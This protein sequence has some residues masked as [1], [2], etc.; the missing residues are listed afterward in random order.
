MSDHASRPGTIYFI[1]EA[2]EVLQRMV[3]TRSKSLLSVYEQATEKICGVWYRVPRKYRKLL[4]AEQ[5]YVILVW[6]GSRQADLALAGTIVLLSTLSTEQFASVLEPSNE[7]NV[8]GAGGTAMI[9]INAGEKPSIHMT[10]ILTGLFYEEDKTKVPLNVRLESP[11]GQTIFSGSMIVDKVNHDHNVIEYQSMVSINVLRMLTRG[12]LNL[13]VESRHTRNILRIT[14]KIIPHAT[15]EV[16]QTVL[17]PLLASDSTPSINAMAWAYIN[18]HG[19]LVYNI[20]SDGLNDHATPLITLLDE[21]VKP[22]K[23]EPLKLPSS[24]IGN[25]ANG[26]LNR[27]KPRFIE[28]FYSN[29]LVIKIITNA[30]SIL[31]GKLIGRPVGGSRSSTEPMLL[32]SPITP[33]SSHLMLKSDNTT[34]LAHLAG[35]VW[36][37][38]DNECTVQYDITINDPNVQQD[39]ELYLEDRPID[40]PNAPLNV[41]LLKT[42]RADYVEGF[43]M[44]LSSGKLNVLERS[45]CI[46]QVKGKMNKMLL[47]QGRLRGVK[48]PEHCHRA[49]GASGNS[50]TSTA[51]NDQGMN[52]TPNKSTK[53]IHGDRDFEDGDFWQNNTA[54]CRMCA[55]IDR[56]VMCEPWL[57]PPLNCTSGEVQSERDGLCCPIC[58]GE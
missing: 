4:Y 55:C 50:S 26:T 30:T 25:T 17:T 43:I 34:N 39:M 23:M 46:L 2:G 28:A 47:L 57:C 36:M 44:K 16:Y 38:I 5:M 19:E 51:M 10:F 31:S 15:C 12:P 41:R 29:N 3:L 13:F 52:E 54:T 33:D 20:R 11:S 56:R 45:H 42:F 32:K 22:H 14:G 6:G 37:S 27:L 49:I 48:V 9:S 35:M 8:L 1:N 40:A 53:C 58:A 21:R 18:Y 24:M 7:P